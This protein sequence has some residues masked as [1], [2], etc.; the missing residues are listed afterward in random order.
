[1]TVKGFSTGATAHIDATQNNCDNLPVPV[2]ITG[3]PNNMY[4]WSPTT[5]LT[6][7]PDAAHVTLN[8]PAS[9][10][11]QVIASNGFC[12]DTLTV[13]ITRH[14]PIGLTVSPDSVASCQPTVTLT[15]SVTTT[16]LVT[17]KWFLNGVLVHTGSP[18]T[19]PTS[20]AAT[21]TVVA[22]DASGCTDSKPVVVKTH[23]PN[24][25]VSSDQANLCD[26]LPV[27]LTVTGDAGNTYSW[28]PATWLTYTPD[29]THV[30]VDPPT[31][32]VY[33]LIVDNGFCKD[34]FP[35]SVT[36][37]TPIGLSVGPDSVFSC[38]P[39]TILTANVSTTSNVTIT[40]LLNGQVVHTGTTFTVSTTPGNTYTVV[41]TDASGCTDSKKVTVTGTAADVSVD[42]T[43]PISACE[44]TPLQL[45]LLNH[46]PGDI[47]TYNWQS[48]G[49]TIT[50]ANAP[51]PTATGPAGSYVITVTVTNQYNCTA[52]LTIPV[53]IQ[54]N[55]VIDGKIDIDL[56]KGKTATFSNTSGQAG[57]WQFGDGLTSTQNP[58]THTYTAAGSYTVHFIPNLP[59]CY[60]P[61]VK[62]INVPD[63]DSVQAAANAVYQNCVAN[64]VIQFNDQTVHGAPIV[65]W[66]WTFSAGTP[67]TSTSQNPTV[68]LGNQTQLTGTLIV[69]DAHGCKDTAVVP[70]QVNIIN[71]TIA[72]SAKYCPGSSI[73]LNPQGAD[74]NYVYHWTS[75][76]ADPNLNA[77]APNPVV[78]PTVTT[79]YSLTITNGLCS[80]TFAETVTPLTGPTVDAGPA[81][82]N[83]CGNGAI[84]LMATHGNSTSIKW[85]DHPNFPNPLLSTTDSL[86]V[87]PTQGTNYYVQVT[88]ADGCTARDT[89][90]VNPDALG[91]QA[92]SPNLKICKGGTTGLNVSVI[93]PN[94]NDQLTYQWSPN[95]PGV[96]NPTVSPSINTTYHVTV[97][98]QNGCK[99]TT[100]FHVSVSSLAVTAHASPDTVFEGQQFTL[101]ATTNNPSGNGV[102][103]HWSPSDSLE[104]PHQSTTLGTI[105]ETTVFTV[106]AN[107]DNGCPDTAHVTVYIRSDE[108]VE[109]Y[110]FV[111]LAFTPNN[112][113][114]NDFFMVRAVKI[115]KLRFIVW[116]RWGEILYETTQPESKGW[117]GTYNGKEL[118]P[119]A[120][121]WYLELYC[122]NGAVY[123][124][125][126]NVTLLK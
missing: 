89:V 67:A 77:S 32:T 55:G 95:L 29:V 64:A 86:I 59:S 5:D 93:N 62:A 124:K 38:Q 58:V 22:T 88:S 57:I 35:V 96:S 72:Q 99:D 24:A 71:D 36:R 63:A 9:T 116:N 18:F 53:T 106:V 111:P 31:T 119:D 37:H 113:G 13:P 42:P 82:L 78:S 120:Y 90:R 15:A 50:P 126:G 70:V 66:N 73:A 81:V 97:T 74:P 69:T 117:D 103:Y 101:T 108:C 75:S 115:K 8:P 105:K 44:N 19:A 16:S 27:H 94:P 114:N 49:L 112:D 109:P 85:S 48:T 51:N 65:S 40:W 43:L 121:P 100:S 25:S 118:T 30:T 11:Y 60:Q 110:V 104:S 54:P 102:S 79:V 14:I 33:D 56:C 46:H 98:N 76:P 84:K 52:T 61:F 83:Y 41:A 7:T 3:D 10:L 17:I 68:T 2:T 123:Q 39:T 28:T 91:I 45:G 4:T 26:N 23:V 125:K 12:K 87:S 122:E 1:V 80:T 107:D 34:T 20:P 21:Y 92:L 6:F 47:L